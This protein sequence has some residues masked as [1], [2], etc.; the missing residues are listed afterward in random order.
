V[1][2]QLHA[3]AALPPGK[4]PLVPIGRCYF[5]IGSNSYK[6]INTVAIIKFSSSHIIIKGKSISIFLSKL[7]VYYL[8]EL[9]A[10][11]TTKRTKGH[12]QIWSITK[13]S[14]TKRSFYKTE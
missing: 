13:K 6:L 2:G 9:K 7:R 5:K 12:K 4:E 8:C 1:G 11:K 3:P 14:S 10:R